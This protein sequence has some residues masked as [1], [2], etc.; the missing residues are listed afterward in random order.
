MSANLGCVIVAVD[1]SEE[2]MNA[3]RYALDNLKLRSPAPDSTETP[4]SFVILHVQPPPSIAAGLNPG[5]IPFGGPSGLEVPAF[6][7]AIEAHQRRITEAILEH[8]LEI[9]REKKVNV[10]TQVVIGDPKEKICEVAENLPADLL[11]M[12]CRSFGPIKS[13]LFVSRMFLGS[14][15]NYCTNQ[16]Q[17]PVIIVK[18]K[19]PSS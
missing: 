12:G 17:C 14:V 15:S 11:V 13:V 10:K 8:A 2:S 19:D 16:A 9:C 1:G 5:A 3:L 4:G 7:A 6:T 18:G